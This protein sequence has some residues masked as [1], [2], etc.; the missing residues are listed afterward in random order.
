MLR[1]VVFG[2][3]TSSH[4]SGNGVTKERSESEEGVDVKDCEATGEAGHSV[5]GQA[6]GHYMTDQEAYSE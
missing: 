2:T 5:K 6:R 1:G 3:I 4:D